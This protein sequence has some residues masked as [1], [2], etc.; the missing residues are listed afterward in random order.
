MH[1]NMTMIV[2]IVPDADGALFA[3]LDRQLL[4]CLEG[5]APSSY[6]PADAAVL[7]AAASSAARAA[8]AATPALC[9]ARSHR[10]LA[11]LLLL[12]GRA[13]LEVRAEELWGRVER[14]EG[15]VERG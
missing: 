1:M 3:G 9:A 6:P 10:R 4:H 12:A 11:L 14:G 5:A 13:V 8:A 15:N 2:I 7:A